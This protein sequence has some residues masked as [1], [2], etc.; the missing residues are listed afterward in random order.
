M[1]ML[2]VVV[3][4]VGSFFLFSV[5]HYVDFIYFSDEIITIFRYLFANF[6]IVINYQRRDETNRKL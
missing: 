3:V 2:V 6:V 1:M 5:F 4:V